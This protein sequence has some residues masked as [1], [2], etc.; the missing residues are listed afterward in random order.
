MLLLEAYLN[1]VD[2]AIFFARP[3]FHTVCA[4]AIQTKMALEMRVWQLTNCVSKRSA[5][6]L[7]K[8]MAF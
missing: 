6:W 1:N 7:S 3:S 8:T 4:V 5:N 2:G